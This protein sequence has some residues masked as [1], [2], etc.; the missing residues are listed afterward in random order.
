MS[1]ETEHGEGAFQ[2]SE[3]ATPPVDTDPKKTEKVQGDPSEYQPGYLGVWHSLSRRGKTAATALSTTALLAA[4]VAGTVVG[5]ES[6]DQSSALPQ[7]TEQTDDP[8]DDSEGTLNTDTESG[9]ENPGIDF[10]TTDDPIADKHLLAKEVL[11]R[12][13]Y[14]IAKQ[15]GNTRTV[16]DIYMEEWKYDAR[17]WNYDFRDE[18]TKMS[19]TSTHDAFRERFKDEMQRANTETVSSG[20]ISRARGLYLIFTNESG[21]VYVLDHPPVYGY[22]KNE[23]TDKWY[24]EKDIASLVPSEQQKWQ[25]Y[26]FMFTTQENSEKRFHSVSFFN[27]DEES[28]HGVF[29]SSYET[30]NGEGF[31]LRAA[32]VDSG[33]DSENGGGAYLESAEFVQNDMGGISTRYSNGAVRQLD[34]AETA[35]DYEETVSR[36]FDRGKV[37]VSLSFMTDL[38]PRQ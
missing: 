6:R 26:F 21:D 20:S 12:N 9:T 18:E 36:F 8:A 19:W 29:L 7:E 23:A 33:A 17:Y 13:D 31:R 34:N 30:D 3:E 11:P 35:S 27:Q 10:M 32:F 37:P 2:E 4:G 25:D 1:S 14:K 38:S 15:E 24:A 5:S 22:R 28:G 16:L